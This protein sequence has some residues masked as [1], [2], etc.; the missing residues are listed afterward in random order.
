MRITH[1]IY[2]HAR[3]PWFG[4][5]GAVRVYEIYK[6]LAKKGHKV[7]IVCRIYPG[8]SD[9][10]EGNLSFKFIGNK[11]NYILSIFSYAF[12]AAGFVKKYGDEFDLIVEDF[13]PWNPLFSKF[14]TKRPVILHINHAE[15]KGILKRWS[16]LGIP[17]FSY[18]EGLSSSF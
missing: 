4:G 3:N 6:E 16:I 2:D 13:A 15:G 9:Y 12:K 18:R 14:F 11:R 8:S 10:D 7:T 5:A 1:L 17:F